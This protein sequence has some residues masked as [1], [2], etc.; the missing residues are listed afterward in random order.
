LIHGWGP[1]A[2]RFEGRS[3]EKIGLGVIGAIIG[4]GLGY[5]TMPRPE[6][7]FASI[8]QNRPPQFGYF[9][10]LCYHVFFGV[11]IGIV[12]GVAIAIFLAKRAAAT[13]A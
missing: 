6:V 10:I 8:N 12:A 5:V 2:R 9:Q 3:H 13:K 1:P 7:W 4:G 11:V